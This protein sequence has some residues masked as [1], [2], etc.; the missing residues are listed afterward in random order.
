MKKVCLLLMLTSTTSA[1]S[2]TG[3]QNI[4]SSGRISRFSNEKFTLKRTPPRQ[5]NY[6]E[7]SDDSIDYFISKTVNR[8]EKP[9]QHQSTCASNRYAAGDWLH[10]VFT[11]P[12]SSVLREIRNPVITITVWSQIVAISHRV[13]ASSASPFLNKIARNMGIGALP[14]S[15]LTSSLGLLLVFRTNS[16]YQ[17]F[18]VR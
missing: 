11:L 14:H 13:L 5:L 8:L 12:R 16:A 15:L 9:C 10:N 17:R 4:Y 1:F 6:Q 7:N 2:N 3:G 18:N